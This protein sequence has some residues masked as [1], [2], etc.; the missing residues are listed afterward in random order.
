MNKK[1]K[2][3]SMPLWKGTSEKPGIE[4]LIPFEIHWNNNGYIQQIISSENQDSIFETYDNDDYEFITNPPGYSEWANKLGDQKINLISYLH[5]SLDHKEILEIGGGS[6]YTA[7]KIL[8]KFDIKK[9][10]L[11]DPAIKEESSDEKIDV[12]KGYFN[13]NIL[14]NKKFDFA[15]C[16][17]VLEHVP[18]P[19]LF[20][21]ELN[22]VLLPKRG[23]A[24]VEI[25]DI[26]R[27]FKTGDL[28][29]LLHE[30]I[31]YFTRKSA[32]EI[33]QFCGF[34]IINEFYANDTLNILIEATSQPKE[35]I[36]AEDDGLI[37]IISSKIESNILRIKNILNT[38]RTNN[39]KIAFHGACNGL[40]T[41]LYILDVHTD[42]NIIIADIDN[43]KTNTYLP[44][45]NKKIV[46]I[47]DERYLTADLFIISSMSFY[48][49]IN[50]FLVN[51]KKI[52]QEKIIPL[53]I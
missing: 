13:F 24:V 12:I 45:F 27:Q 11:V 40:N 19:T 16:F 14:Q 25:P 48:S 2:I 7:K 4:A 1:L 46:S 15:I 29:A 28:N 47:N 31:S 23:R 30:H 36:I 44:S 22:K 32:Y 52:P 8:G 50:N 33:I 10:T 6:L 39:K 35:N 17:S 34:N 3:R 42:E 26:E 37:D 5:G 20:L 41:L 49:E 53:F 18:D 43:S 51:E 38:E 9:Y 21:A